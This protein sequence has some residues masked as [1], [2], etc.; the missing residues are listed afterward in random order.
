MN[1]GGLNKMIHRSQ[2]TLIRVQA[3]IGRQKEFEASLQKLRGKDADVSHEADEIQVLIS[4]SQL[5]NPVDIEI[6]FTCNLKMI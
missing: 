2:L 4:N 6:L 3:K 5:L 1:D